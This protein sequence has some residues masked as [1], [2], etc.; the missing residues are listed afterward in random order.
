MYYTA[1]YL[2]PLG[3]LLLA[4]DGKAVTGVWFEG[5][6]YF[7]RTLAG[8]A[9]C[10]GHDPLMIRLR[11]FLDRYFAGEQPPPDLPLD[12]AGSAFQKSVWAKLLQIPY[13]RVTTYGAIANALS[14]ERGAAVSAR[15][16][17]GA[18]GRNPISILIP[19]HRVIGA[20]AK[21]TGYAAGLTVKQA[22][23]ALETQGR[24]ACTDD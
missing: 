22:L 3:K 21:P 15:A 6:K 18:V 16:V 20:G 2:S 17:G 7:A 13:G 19:C 14:E 10:G 11:D 5:Q 4:C 8:E 24:A 9:A 1:E 23:L 12:P